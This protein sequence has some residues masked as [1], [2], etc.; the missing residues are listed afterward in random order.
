MIVKNH[1]R[2]LD[3]LLCAQGHPSEITRPSA[4]QINCSVLF[5]TFGHALTCV[6]LRN[7]SPANFPP[8]SQTPSTLA[9][10]GV[11]DSPRKTCARTFILPASIFASTHTGQL[12][13]PY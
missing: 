9:S 2:V 3:A 11:A 10:R 1:V 5:C 7:N 8:S 13:S 4:N 12:Q 6:L